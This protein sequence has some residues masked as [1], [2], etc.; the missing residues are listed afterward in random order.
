MEIEK[1]TNGYVLKIYPD[2]YVYSKLEEV[3]A[4][5]VYHIRLSEGS[6]KV[7]EE[8]EISFKTTAGRLIHENVDD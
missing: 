6:Y 8:T 7:G 5:I 2:T 4:Q 3:F 1:V